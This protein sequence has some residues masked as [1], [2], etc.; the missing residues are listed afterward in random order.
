M[1]CC[2]HLLPAVAEAHHLCFLFPYLLFK[3]SVVALY[4]CGLAVSTVAFLFDTC[5]R[6]F[7]F[8]FVSCFNV[9]LSSVFFHMSYNNLHYLDLVDR[10]FDIALP[11]TSV[12]KLPYFRTTISIQ[13]VQLCKHVHCAGFYWIS[14]CILTFKIIKNSLTVYFVT[15]YSLCLFK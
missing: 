6:Q 1:Y 2:L 8:L 15:F 10:N 7:H 4:L 13:W 11:F 12:L 9:G 14:C 3:Y 5:Q